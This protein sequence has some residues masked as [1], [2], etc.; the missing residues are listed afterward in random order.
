MPTQ[1]PSAVTPSW[2]ATIVRGYLTLAAIGGVLFALLPVLFG[3]MSASSYISAGLMI[4]SSV[5]AAGL[6]G[7]VVWRP[8]ATRTV[9]IV[10]GLQVMSSL[11][12]L[13]LLL[14]E[15]QMSVAASVVL[16]PLLFGLLVHRRWVPVGLGLAWACLVLMGAAVPHETAEV[17]DLIAIGLLSALIGGLTWVVEGE[18][19]RWQREALV[20]QD[21][22]RETAERAERAAAA[23]ATFLATMSHEIRTPLHGVLG[24]NQALRET[25]LS[26]EQRRLL[27]T[28]LSSG[29]LLQAVVND[30]LDLTRLESGQLTFE[31]G[32]VDIR[33]LVDEVRRLLEPQASGGGLELIVE[34]AADV[35]ERLR[36]DP[37]RVEQV[38]FNLI[39]NALK[40]TER[41]EVRVQV[42]WR[43]DRLHVDVLDTGIGIEPDRIPAL[44][45][46]FVQAETSTSRRFGGSGLGLAICRQLCRRMGGD[47]GAG[48]RDGGGSHFWFTVAAPRASV[49]PRPPPSRDDLSGLRILVVEDNPVN[50]LVARKLLERLGAE[51]S[52][53]DDGRVGLERLADQRFDMVLM[54]CHMPVMDGFDTTRAIRSDERLAGLP[55][56]AL[57]AS[58]TAE[59]REHALASGMDAVVAKPIDTPALIAT[60]HTVMR[61][62][63]A[64]Q[65]SAG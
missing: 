3:P 61:E 47:V 10:L 33:A 17:A 16:G 11:V 29:R 50:Q 12:V 49:D 44:F 38:L 39:G 46:P 37:T 25:T 28:A 45:E 36:L 53:A 65:A 2:R 20:R 63:A 52:V 56:I 30:I 26:D 14:P 19:E 35:P 64:E 13:N 42:R 54:D 18:R 31:M 43:E 55:V 6:L 27:D 9:A 59:D 32:E 24:L 8:T 7:L 58:V 34:V 15:P 41:G 62:K 23:R 51:C 40:F 60:V 22:L 57:T 1:P 4:A 48:P 5:I 21:A